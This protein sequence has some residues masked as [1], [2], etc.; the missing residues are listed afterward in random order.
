MLLI[1]YQVDT[2]ATRRPVANMAIV[3]I[4][5][6]VSIMAFRG[7]LP[8][9]DIRALVLDGWSVTGIFGH[10]LLHGGIMHLVGNMVMLWIFGN[11]ICGIMGQFGFALLYLFTG[12]LAACAQVAF[13]GNPA[14]GAS[15]AVS[16]IMGVYLAVYPT[17]HVTC[18]WNWWLR[19]GT[20]DLSGW[21]LIAGYFALDLLGLIGSADS[22]AHWAHVGGTVAGFG[23][24]LVMLKL[25]LFD[26]QSYDLPTSLD[27]ISRRR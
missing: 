18:F 3:A 20:F 13:D 25:N 16:G 2:L 21:V 10:I 23:L 11:A 22:V 6:V 17:N 12:V 8:K 19:W 26:L 15:G 7:A 4:T 14:I 1:P 9:A 24:G 5:C 27:Y